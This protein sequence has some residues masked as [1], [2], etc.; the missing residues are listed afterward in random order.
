MHSGTF[1]RAQLS[2]AVHSAVESGRPSESVIPFGGV[3][4]PWPHSGPASLRGRLH[5]PHHVPHLPRVPHGQPLA[6]R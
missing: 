6:P 5:R 3:L 1:A 2:G 4:L